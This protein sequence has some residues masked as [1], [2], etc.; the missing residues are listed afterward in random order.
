MKK[1]IAAVAALAI[2]L[3]IYF[4]GIAKTDEP[5][6]PVAVQAPVEQPSA[7]QNPHAANWGWGTKQEKAPDPK[8][9]KNKF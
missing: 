5:K 9:Y 3:G 4:F 7:A 6:P 1:V 8:D 2:G